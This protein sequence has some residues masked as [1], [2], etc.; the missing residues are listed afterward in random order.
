MLATQLESCVGRPV[1]FGD[2][3]TEVECIS[4]CPLLAAASCHY[5][6]AQQPRAVLSP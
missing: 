5:P 3:G 4:G 2:A 1:T 6:L